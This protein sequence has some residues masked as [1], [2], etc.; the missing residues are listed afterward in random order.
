MEKLVQILVSLFTSFVYLD[1]LPNLSEPQFPPL[2]NNNTYI[3]ILQGLNEICKV[4]KYVK[5]WFSQW[6]CT[7][8]RV[9]R[10]LKV[11]VT[12]WY[13]TLCNPMDCSPPSSSV[14]GIL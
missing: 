11:K 3:T 2:K 8:V 14:H 4:L 9:E 12:Q 7:D 1:K 5:L 13:L 6:F 10:R